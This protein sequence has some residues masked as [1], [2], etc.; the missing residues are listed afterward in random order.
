MRFI[1]VND[2]M[3]RAA[4]F[5]ALCCEPITESYVREHQTRLA[6]CCAEHYLGHCPS[7]GRAS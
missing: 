1:V 4:T 2:R 6:Y 3:P 7:S 5:C